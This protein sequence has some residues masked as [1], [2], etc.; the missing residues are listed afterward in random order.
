MDIFPIEG[1]WAGRLAVCSRPRSGG[2]LDD[3][4]QALQRAGFDTLISAITPE[5]L[6]K[7]FLEQVPEACER[8]RVTWV[9]FP[10]GN[11]QVPSLEIARPAIESWTRMLAAG[12]GLAVHCWGSIGRSPTLAASMLVLGGVEPGAAWERVQLARGKPVP[13]TQ[14]QRRWIEAFAPFE[15]GQAAG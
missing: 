12:R 2:W 13:D 15:T 1:P 4:I 9:H 3:D 14:E 7:L 5:E 11:L 6:V 10:V 8:W